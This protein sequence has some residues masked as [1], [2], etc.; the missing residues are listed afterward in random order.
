[1]NKDTRDFVMSRGPLSLDD[2][3]LPASCEVASKFRGRDFQKDGPDARQC[4]PCL[5]LRQKFIGP[6]GLLFPSKESS[7]PAAFLMIEEQVN[8]HNS[9]EKVDVGEGEWLST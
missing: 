9:D 3:P 6:K 4:L 1:M 2:V 5:P 7:L 8:N